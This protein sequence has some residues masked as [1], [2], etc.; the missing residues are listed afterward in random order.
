MPPGGAAAEV[1]T[2]HDNVARLHPVLKFRP[3]A[4]EGVLR[5]L[6]RRIQ[7]QEPAGD[8]RVR[9]YVVAEFPYLSHA[10]TLLGSVILPLIAE[11]AAV[12]GELR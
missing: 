4:L 9:V 6:L 3:H 11:A 5:Q 2:G 7:Y 10:H 8:D 12:A 1:V